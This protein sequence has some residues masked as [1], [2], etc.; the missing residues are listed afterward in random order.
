MYFSAVVDLNVHQPRKIEMAACTKATVIVG[1]WHVAGVEV[2][3]QRFYI[4]RK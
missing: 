1:I 3:S 2:F 4:V